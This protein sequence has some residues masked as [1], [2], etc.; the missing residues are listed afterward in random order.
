MSIGSHRRSSSADLRCVPESSLLLTG[1]PSTSICE[2]CTCTRML[3]VSAFTA[4]VDIRRTAAAASSHARHRVPSRCM[5][6]RT[7]AND[8]TTVRSGR[9]RV[10]RVGESASAWCLFC[11]CVPTIPRELAGWSRSLPCGPLSARCSALALAACDSRST[12]TI[13]TDRPHTEAHPPPT[14]V[15]ARGGGAA[16]GCAPGPD[17]EIFE[18]RRA[19]TIR[20]DPASTGGGWKRT[21]GCQR[22]GPILLSHLPSFVVPDMVSLPGSRWFCVG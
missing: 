8:V 14:Y 5:A 18:S 7:E 11:P 19:A 15:R 9:V 20:M 12:R 2:P 3:V 6:D 16:R 17:R 10:L 22:M 21:S 4:R 1:F 13:E